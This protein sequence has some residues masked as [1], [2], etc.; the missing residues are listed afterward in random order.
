MSSPDDPVQRFYAAVTSGDH[1]SL[2]NLCAAACIW[3]LPAF[4]QEFKGSDAAELAAALWST[5]LRDMNC[6]IVH[7]LIGDG[8]IHTVVR[9]RGVHRGRLP[10]SFSDVPPL[11]RRVDLT[12]Y[13]TFRLEDGLVSEVFT[14]VDHASLRTT[15]EPPRFTAFKGIAKSFDALDRHLLVVGQSGSGKSYFLGT[16]MEEIGGKTAARLVVLDRAGDFLRL[17]VDPRGV[18][19]SGYRTHVHTKP[20]FEPAVSP[21]SMVSPLSVHVNWFSPHDLCAVLSLPIT[22]E[23]WTV[24]GQA[25][26]WVERSLVERFDVPRYYA[27][28]EVLYDLATLVQG[29]NELAANPNY[30]LPS[31]L[32]NVDALNAITDGLLTA[33]RD[34]PASAPGSDAAASFRQTAKQ[35][36]PDTPATVAAQLPNQP[37]LH[38]VDLSCVSTEHGRLVLIL[39]V[40]RSIWRD[41]LAQWR[42]RNEAISASR[43]FVRTPTFVFLDEAHHYVSQEIPESP[44]AE[45]VREAILELATEGRKYGLWLVCGT[46]RPTR[47]HQTI[48]SEASN[49]VLMRTTSPL[50]LDMLAKHFANERIRYILPE[51]KRK[52]GRAYLAGEWAKDGYEAVTTRTRESYHP[53]G[54][55]DLGEWVS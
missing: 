14:S 52:E 23:Y 44:I 3:R 37:D 25:Q 54:S 27:L 10:G 16:L 35:M 1:S 8:I 20:T 45:R 55:L 6:E 42:L 40:L 17:S 43:T 19:D 30:E 13:E 4:E 22:P 51:L 28:D 2:R 29:S 9:L 18:G 49:F 47:L 12:I 38:V 26:S 36:E 33:Q 24:L 7:T 31:E 48:V 34:A 46:Q 39:A 21:D 41:A 50:D 32:F 5:A 53:E 15:L 11:R